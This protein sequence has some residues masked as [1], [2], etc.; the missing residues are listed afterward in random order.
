MLL[1]FL[2]LNGYCEIKFLKK[3]SYPWHM[4]CTYSHKVSDDHLENKMEKLILSGLVN[5]KLDNSI[6]IGSGIQKEKY[7]Y[8]I[9]KNGGRLWELERKPIWER[10]C[11]DSSYQDNLNKNIQYFELDCLIKNIGYQFSK[12]A[13]DCGLY[14]YDINTLKLVDSYSCLLYWKEFTKRYTWRALLLESETS[15]IDWDYYESCR[16]WWR[17]LNELQKYIA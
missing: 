11:S 10:Y 13:L 2:A 6:D 1:D 12:C 16:T 7:I 3:D 8:S 4:N 9:T 5:K 14:Q 17:D 15:T